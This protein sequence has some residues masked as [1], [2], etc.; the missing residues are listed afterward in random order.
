[1]STHFVCAFQRV[2][3]F[4]I[5]GGQKQGGNVAAYF[6]TPDGLVLH[7][8]AGPVDEETFLREARWAVDL[9]QLAR[10]EQQTSPAQL[11]AFFQKAHLQRLRSEHGCH[12]KHIN[13]PSNVDPRM[14]AM[15]LDH[16]RQ[17]VP[18]NQGQVHLLL[19]V[20]PLPPLEL[21]YS[22][23]FEK[24]LNERISTNPVAVAG[25]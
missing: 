7:A 10:L 1:M 15:L 22:V 5:T 12:P 3:T 19:T 2:A 6:C 23:V 13:I 21:I 24:I 17:R 4:R 20:A 25:R 8:I 9:F 16:S 18:S 14:L 11:S